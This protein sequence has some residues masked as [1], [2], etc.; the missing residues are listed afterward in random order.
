MVRPRR[1]FVWLTMTALALPVLAALGTAFVVD[2]RF[3][4]DNLTDLLADADRLGQLSLNT[5]LVAGLAVIISLVMGLPLALLVFRT[6][7]PG[8]HFWMLVL[9]ATCCLPG[10]VVVTSWLTIADLHLWNQ[11]V[12]A[13]GWV[14][15]LTY[16]PLVTL[17]CGVAL[18][19][20]D[21]T[22]EQL[23]ML[24]ARRRRVV[25]SV[26]LRQAAW[27]IFCAALVVVILTI[28]D[29][30][31]TDILLVRT[32]TEQVFAEFQ[33]N[34]TAGP[35]AAVALPLLAGAVVL[36]LVVLHL[37]RDI[38]ETQQQVAEINPIRFPLGRWKLPA[39]AAVAAVLLLVVAPFASLLRQIP[40][41]R[42]FLRTLCN[43]DLELQRSMI[44]GGLA[45]VIIAVLA[46]APAWALVRSRRLRP[47]VYAWLILLMVTP[48]PLVGIGITKLMNR[49]GLFGAL[50]DSPFIVTIAL[51]VRFLPYQV[52][53]M[54]PS[55]RAVPV[56]LEEDAFLCGANRWQTIRHVIMPLCRRAALAGCVIVFVLGVGEVGATVLV[57]PPGPTTLTIHFFTLIHYGVY[58]DAAAICLILTA[59]VVLPAAVLGICFRR[60]I[61]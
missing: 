30:T 8:R 35:A 10:Y 15:G 6:D 45:V 28:S 36:G 22:L 48:A 27:G 47:L 23:A 4:W 19:C 2:G 51:V 53:A 49:P 18:Q 12:L 43:V 17:I 38:G 24:D 41:C 44:L 7:V 14:L 58:A 52:L 39:V 25:W 3:G 57:V 1:W 5:I 37:L 21:P 34:R 42:H 61:H 31:V 9:V 11:R 56:E 29:I 32:F 13:A 50:Y 60:F 55:L 46:W 16:L 40:S 59:A 54:L 33:L 26:T 20:V